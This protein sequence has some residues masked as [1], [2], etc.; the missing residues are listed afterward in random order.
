M[1]KDE[2][3]AC[4]S[5]AVLS[6]FG[7]VQGE[8]QEARDTL[9]LKMGLLKDLTGTGES[10]AML[11]KIG[12]VVGT[13]DNLCIQGGPYLACTHGFLFTFYGV[14]ATYIAILYQSF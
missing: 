7:A 10:P 9:L 5:T 13:L 1:A 4:R 3:S 14:L 8:A 6:A 11:Q 2:V 12:L